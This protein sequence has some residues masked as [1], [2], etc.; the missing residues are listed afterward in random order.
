[1]NNSTNGRKSNLHTLNDT[2]SDDHS[3][4]NIVIVLSITVVLLAIIVIIFYWYRSRQVP[5]GY[6]RIDTTNNVSRNISRNNSK[7]KL[8]LQLP[9]VSVS[10]AEALKK[11]SSDGVSIEHHFLSIK[12]QESLDVVP[13]T[14]ATPLTP[15]SPFH[16]QEFPSVKKM[17]L[18]KSISLPAKSVF[19]GKDINADGLWRN[20]VK[21]ATNTQFLQTQ[22]KKNKRLS[23][24]ASG[25]IK[26]S[27][28]Y[29][30]QNQK[31]LIVKVKRFFWMIETFIL[32][33]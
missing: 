18:A 19:A 12:E 21:K 11:K 31:E 7:P 9:K 25:K 23:Y 33:S 16:Q 28:V 13:K 14:P 30:T 24:C 29:D 2:G 27:L 22:P 5:V 17:T 32:F 8:T 15:V 4:E 3:S 20:A 26:F 6:K 10:H 1:M